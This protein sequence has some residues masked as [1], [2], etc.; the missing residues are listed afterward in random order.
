MS[1]KRSPNAKR[2][3]AHLHHAP[4]AVHARVGHRPGGHLARERRAAA[5]LPLEQFGEQVGE[6]RARHRGGAAVDAHETPRDQRRHPVER[7]AR[8]RRVVAVEVVPDGRAPLD[9]KARHDAH[10]RA[11]RA[12]QAGGA[13]G[14]ATQPPDRSDDATQLALRHARHAEGEEATLG[15]HEEPRHLLVGTAQQP[16]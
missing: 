4:Q 14:G 12:R 7:D 2:R 16:A 11:D 15:A 5:Q 6:S 9:A 13:G 1:I 3:P 8:Q 10:Q